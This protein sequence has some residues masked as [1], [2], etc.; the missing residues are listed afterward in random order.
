MLVPL[1]AFGAD[2]P[3]SAPPARSAVASSQPADI[4]AQVPSEESVFFFPSLRVDAGLLIDLGG[5]HAA[6]F[7]T[8]VLGGVMIGF[9]HVDVTLLAEAGYQYGYGAPQHLGSVG[10]VAAYGHHIVDGGGRIH[11]LF[12]T[13]AGAF[14]AGLSLSGFVGFYYESFFLDVGYQT[15]FVSGA[16]GNQ[17]RLSAGVNIPALLTAVFLNTFLNDLFLR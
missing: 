9:K 16:N 3:P 7:T 6:D 13:D 17:L 10:V 4:S 11:G 14:A 15:L 5:H 12:G 1:A 8:A 2:V